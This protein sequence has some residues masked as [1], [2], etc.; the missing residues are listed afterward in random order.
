MEGLLKG[1]LPHA[2][3]LL[4]IN[5]RP[6]VVIADL[7]GDNLFEVT[8]VYKYRGENYLII[9]KWQAGAWYVAANA[10][11][12]GYDITDFVVAPVTRC[13]VNDLI[14]GW[15][16]AGI[17]S[18]LEIYQFMQNS[19]RGV[20]QKELY[21]SKLEIEDMPNR[22]GKDGRA[23]IA[24]WVHD[25]GEAYRIDLYRWCGDQLV[26]AKDVSPYYYQRILRYY[27]RLVKEYPDSPTYLYY[28][29]NAQMQV[30]LLQEALLS[31]EK[32]LQLPYPYP[33]KEELIQLKE[34]L[35]K[36][37]ERQQVDLSQVVSVPSESKRDEALEDAFARVFELKRG[38]DNVRYYYNR[39]D[40][41]DDGEEEVFVY[42]V[43]P[44]VCGTGGC[45]AAIFETINGEYRLLSR[46]SLVRS[47][48]IIEEKK[49]NGYRNIVMYVSGGG[50]EPF[51]AEL[52]FDG[53]AYPLNP[54]I[55]PKVP[56]GTL[57]RGEAI[58]ADNLVTNPGIQF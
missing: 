49:S 17:W 40:L 9:L 2:A 13:G 42:L 35:S 48:I 20:M 11:G 8:G 50:I 32:D 43:G 19:I 30:G 26:P 12:K 41:N 27:S 5:Q 52:T 56:P 14:I 33:S 46:F 31:I 16:V 18:V 21:F 29:A 1:V 34:S 53:K 28:L 24:L 15:Q 6:V 51:Y 45:S 55:Q 10:K 7:D 36:L 47:P 44:F 57:L 37:S 25:T 4:V 58:I 23:E 38:V 3:E 22:Y 39:I 54:S